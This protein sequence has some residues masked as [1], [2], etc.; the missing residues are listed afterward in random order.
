[1]FCQGKTGL[2][3]SIGTILWRNRDI[4]TPSAGDGTGRDGFALVGV[5]L[6]LLV[7]TAAITPFVLAARTDLAI[8]SGSYQNDR[9]AIL[10]EGLAGVINAKLAV[11]AE[12]AQDTGLQLNSEPM[13]TV[14]GQMQVEIT[15][16]DQLGLVDLN[17]A[18]PELLEAGFQSLGVALNDARK[19]ASVAD[20]FRRPPD[21]GQGNPRET[22]EAL[23]NGLKNGPYEAIEELYELR[24]LSGVPLVNLARAFTVY[25]RS[26][27]I[28]A[29]NM[30]APL[31]KILPD[32]PSARYPFV[33]ADSDPGT[34]FRVDVTV[35]SRTSN[36]AGFSGTII[37][38]AR[39]EEGNYKTIEAAT[40]PAFLETTRAPFAANIR[41]QELFGQEIAAWIGQV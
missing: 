3:I 19:S 29:A 34:I 36:F 25:G 28:S 16:Q 33:S 18:P 8:A 13:R 20:A 11:P 12:Q 35:R 17:A 2:R 31:A 39:D 21:A 4:G 30:S 24:S 27:E 22:A 5:L 14:C 23:T 15:V 6:F 10:A 7:V 26:P 37:E 1:M 32:A 41:C 38:L 9:L 40:N